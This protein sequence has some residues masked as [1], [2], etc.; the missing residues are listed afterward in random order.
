MMRK[1]FSVALMAFAFG[2]VQ[3]ANAGV[4][5]DLHFRDATVPTGITINAGDLGPGCLFG[6]YA[7]G[8]VAS[9]YCMDVV[10]TSDH[11]FVGM[12][13]TVTYDSDNGLAIGSMYEW[14]GPVVGWSRGAPNAWCSPPGGLQD[15][16]GEI[17][18]FDCVVAPPAPPPSVAAGTYTIGTIVWD[19]SGTTSGTEVIAAMINDLIDGVAAIING[20]VVTLT[21]A[22]VVV[23]SHILTII[24]EPGTAS[25]LGLGLVG[26]ILAGRRRS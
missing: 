2:L 24:P 15:V 3:S 13:A 26:L 17:R 6:G 9:G 7:G 1:V 12:A 21:S 19:T 20:N 25:L 4:T 23:G 14:V 11:A 16:G 18:S 5:I 8:S 10:M 22:D